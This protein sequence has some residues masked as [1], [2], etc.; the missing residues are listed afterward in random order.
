MPFNEDSRVK[1]PAILH[2]CRL[3]YEYVPLKNAN[4]DSRT[5]IFTDI[6]REAVC[7]INAGMDEDQADRLYVDLSMLLDNEDLGRAFYDKITNESG[8]KIIDFDNFS[9]NRFHVVTELPYENDDESFRPD[10]TL[11]INGIPL[12]F[13]EVKKPNNREGIL[14]ERNRINRRCQNRKFRRFMNITQLMVFS[15]NMA[16]DE[17]ETEPL[18]GAFYACPSYRQPVFN[19]FREEETLDLAQLL[20]ADNDALE[21]FVLKDNNLIVIKNSPEFLTNKN[22]LTPTNRI[23]TSL[24]SWP[25]LSFFLKYA[26]A[27]VD[28]A[29][30]IEKHVMRYPQFFAAR[31]ISARLDSGIR[32]GIIWHTQGSGKTALAYYSVRYLTDYFQKQQTIPKFYFIV[33]RID[34]LTQ[35]KREFTARGLIVHTVVSKSAFIKSIKAVTA[36][37]NHSGKAEITVVNIQKFSD[38]AYATQ[39]Q[40]YNISIQRIYFLD[41]VHRSYNPKG[42]FLANLRQSDPNAIKIGLTGTP[43][44]SSQYYSRDL[45]GNYIHKYYYNASIADGYTLRLIREEITSDYKIKLRDALAKLPVQKGEIKRSEVFSKRSFVK[46]F[47][48]YILQDFEKSR[49]SLADN[50]IGGMVVCDSADQARMMFK[51]FSEETQQ[52]AFTAGTDEYAYAAFETV[53]YRA[54]DGDKSRVGSAALILHDAGTKEEQKQIVEGFKNGY[55]DLLFVYNMLLTGFDARRLKKLYLG[56]VVK[57]HN[58]LQTLTRVNRTYRNHKYGYVVDFADIKAEFDATNRAYFDELQ[59]ELGDELQMYSSLFKSKEE[60]ETEI[61][62]IK[63]TLFQFDT[64]NKEIFSRQL[65]QIDDR[66]QMLQLTKVLENAKSLY[67]MIRLLGHEDLLEKVDFRQLNELYKDA[68]ARLDLLNLRENLRNKTDHTDLLNQ[69]LED[70]LFSF[71]KVSEEELVIADQLRNSLRK[72]RETMAGNIDQHDPE[73][74]ALFDELKRLFEKKNLDEVSTAEMNRN[75]GALNKI[76]VKVK[77]LNRKNDLLKT[78]YGS[79]PKFV[80]IHKRIREKGGFTQKESQ[81][82]EALASLKNKADLKVLQNTRLL[83]NEEYFSGEMIRMVIDEFRNV[84]KIKLDAASSKYINKLVV[85]E[86]VSEFQGRVV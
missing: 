43:L 59:S 12:A 13:I 52:D 74:V 71:T 42:S 67:N 30:G 46:I 1:I 20:A 36:L 8:T 63:E 29:K 33:D 3:G 58:L 64:L 84:H 77:E 37:H 28:E 61:A 48:E 65:E 66:E 70:V 60:M 24:F 32:K 62:E 79:D 54:G 2:L 85:Q 17:N 23:L 56:R 4:R 16:Y 21:T 18:Q 26:F 5:N 9:A 14:S 75:I 40:D 22:P 44:I 47:L 27:Y 73:F 76:Y 57:K 34:L 81:I 15:N 45:F 83:D 39:Q 10:I 82:F 68:K 38:D 11:L 86:Y 80:R 51:I 78:K 41:E 53:S 35:A 25:R 19:Y 72:T 49:K 55:I 50:T 31:A 7:R 6:F 69:A